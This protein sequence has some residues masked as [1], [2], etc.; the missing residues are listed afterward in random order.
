[1]HCYNLVFVCRVAVSVFFFS[2]FLLLLFWIIWHTCTQAMLCVVKPLS[3]E[4]WGE[5]CFRQSKDNKLYWWVVF[6]I[7]KYYIKRQKANDIVKS[8]CCLRNWKDWVKM[9]KRRT[10]WQRHSRQVWFS[11]WGRS[12]VSCALFLFK[13]TRKRSL[14]L[15]V[16]LHFEFFSSISPMSHNDNLFADLFFF[17]LSLPHSPSPSLYLSLLC[18]S[19]SSLL[20]FCCC[21]Y[22]FHCFAV[23][24]THLYIHFNR[25]KAFDAPFVRP[26]ILTKIIKYDKTV[27]HPFS[28]TCPHVYCL[29]VAF[30]WV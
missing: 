4:L 25:K 18:L 29:S 19:F 15:N 5:L 30:K 10:I 27:F 11:I 21:S 26:L 7:S 28:H 2:L 17:T 6:I 9:T 20:F 22:S 1:M 23:F 13:W 12:I 16:I 8:E 3:I 24:S 14:K